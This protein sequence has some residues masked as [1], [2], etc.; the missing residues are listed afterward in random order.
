MDL[1]EVRDRLRAGL[2]E[3]R[4]LRLESQERFGRAPAVQPEEEQMQRALD[5]FD[6][7]IRSIA[8]KEGDQ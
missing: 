5:E 8:L 6:Y 3:I 7:R 4:A 2:R 1:F